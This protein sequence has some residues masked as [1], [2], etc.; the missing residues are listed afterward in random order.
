MFGFFK[1]K[2]NEP[3]KKI[4]KRGK[5]PLARSDRKDSIRDYTIKPR[6]FNDLREAQI[7]GTLRTSWT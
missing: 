3:K 5:N 6:D 7:S 2:E 4:D 1:K